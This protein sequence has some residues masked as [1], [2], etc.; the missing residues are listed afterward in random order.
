VSQVSKNAEHFTSRRQRIEIHFDGAA[1]SLCSIT[2]DHQIRMVE[3]AILTGTV[4]ED[5]EEK[6]KEM[7]IALFGED[8]TYFLLNA[9]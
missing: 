6:H 4:S 2:P 1:D 8:P 9:F 5:V 3:F 7:K